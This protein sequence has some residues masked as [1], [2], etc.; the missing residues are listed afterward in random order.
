MVYVLPFISAAIGWFTNYLAVK[1]LF[2]PRN[3][4]KIGPLVIQGVFPKRQELIAQNIGSMVANE[5]LSIRDLLEKLKHPEQMDKINDVLNEKVAVYVDEVFP[6]KFPFLAM[7][8]REKRRAKLKQE[9]SDEIKI[10]L[11]QLIDQYAGDIE[12]AISIES[13]IAEKI[14]EMSPAMLEELL[15]KVMSKE[16]KF[17]EIIGAVVGFLIGLLQLGMVQLSIM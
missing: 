17:I 3:R 15:M 1:M 12:E 11:P 16:F 8:V 14:R 10:L 5:L 9:F 2:R 6:E 7:L 4:V 13:T